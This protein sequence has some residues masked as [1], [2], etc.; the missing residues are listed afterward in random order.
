[1]EFKR[2][3]ARREAQR[4][5]ENEKKGNLLK[6]VFVGIAIWADVNR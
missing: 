2:K 4:G 1:V 5:A 6:D 3:G